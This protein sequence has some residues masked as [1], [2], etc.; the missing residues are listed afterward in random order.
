MKINSI[1]QVNFKSIYHRLKKEN[2][3]KVIQIKDG[4]VDSLK[5]ARFNE[6]IKK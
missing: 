5:I 2:P 1:E 4:I 6:N 3:Q